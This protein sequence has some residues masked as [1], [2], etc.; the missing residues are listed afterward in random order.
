MTVWDFVQDLCRTDVARKTCV[1]E[2]CLTQIP[3]EK[4]DLDRADNSDTAVRVVGPS[5]AP[6]Q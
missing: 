2:P 6:V 5:I 3:P 1:Q 4:N